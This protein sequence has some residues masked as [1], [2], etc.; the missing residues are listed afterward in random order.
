MSSHRAE[1]GVNSEFNHNYLTFSRF[2]TRHVGDMLSLQIN[3][4]NDDDDYDG[5]D[6]AFFSGGK[7]KF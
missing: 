2:E 1:P 6:D 5:D 4:K 7:N 3:K